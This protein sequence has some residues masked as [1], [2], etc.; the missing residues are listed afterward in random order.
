MPGG[1]PKENIIF[2]TSPKWSRKNR[3]DINLDNPE[4]YCGNYGTKMDLSLAYD[5]YY[6]ANSNSSHMTIVF[7]VFVIYTLFNQVN[8]R[9]IDDSLNIFKRVLFF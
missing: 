9:M 8:C 5:E 2:G 3:L 1:A 6:S 4:N 7:N